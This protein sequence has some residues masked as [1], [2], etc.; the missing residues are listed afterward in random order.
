MWRSE[1]LPELPL[2]QAGPEVLERRV[3]AL[4]VTHGTHEASR[5]E[6][7]RDA[8]CRREV[9]GKWLLHEGVYTGLGE[10]TRDPFV[11][12]RG[13]GDHAVVQLHGEQVVP[14]GEDRYAAGRSMTVPLSVHHSRE[15]HALERSQ[16]AGMV[17][18]H[19]AEADQSRP[20]RVACSRHQAP[21]LA[22]ALTAAMT[23]ST[24][25]SDSVG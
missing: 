12:G 1:D 11:L 4:D 16:H 21:A 23:R 3:V 17:A 8:L 7:L 14:R 2:F 13:H 6:G 15:M 25:S 18:T 10:R 19:H 22:P 20:E 9:D 24:S 5:L